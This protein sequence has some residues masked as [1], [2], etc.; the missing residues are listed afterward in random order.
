MTIK[1]TFGA[2]GLY[3]S[4]VQPEN[5]L[6]LHQSKME[7]GLIFMSLWKPLLRANLLLLQPT[8]L[9]PTS[10]R[11]FLHG[12]DTIFPRVLIAHPQTILF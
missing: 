7:D 9:L 10:V 4:N 3:Y 1:V 8:N 11:S 12:K 6:I 2:W 5:S